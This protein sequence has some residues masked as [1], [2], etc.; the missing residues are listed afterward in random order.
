MSKHNTAPASPDPDGSEASD[1]T[2]SENDESA[3]GIVFYLILKN[4]CLV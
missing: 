3:E 2:V 1:S 4:E